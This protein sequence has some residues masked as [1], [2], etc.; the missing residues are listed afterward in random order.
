V[1]VSGAA[2]VTVATG[3]LALIALSITRTPP[4]LPYTIYSPLI[5]LAIS[6]R[7]VLE[8]RSSVGL[9]ISAFLRLLEAHIDPSKTWCDPP[10]TLDTLIEWLSHEKG[11]AV[12]RFVAE[13]K[14]YRLNRISD[15]S[16]DSAAVPQDILDTI[17]AGRRERWL[18]NPQ[19]DGPFFK[20]TP[21]LRNH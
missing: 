6:L 1:F 21:F 20:S 9:S 7:S 16:T 5:D 11:V 10:I 19:N 12:W 8:F 3:V 15:P 18:T 17:E 2:C 14:T 4:D 13:F